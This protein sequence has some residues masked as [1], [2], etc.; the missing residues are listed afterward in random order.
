MT[1]SIA[2]IKMKCL[3]LVWGLPCWGTPERAMRLY[4]LQQLRH[5]VATNTIDPGLRELLQE[6]SNN[7][8]RTPRKSAQDQQPLARDTKERNAAVHN[9]HTVTTA[10]SGFGK[11]FSFPR[12]FHFTTKFATEQVKNFCAVNL[13][14]GMARFWCS[15]VRMAASTCC[16]IDGAQR[17]SSSSWK[18]LPIKQKAMILLTRRRLSTA[19]AFATVVQLST[20][21]R[22]QV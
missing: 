7:N 2:T 11:P 6:A 4:Q 20:L 17:I 21:Q 10:F 3:I 22:Y 1:N 8:A 16:Y 9:F 5:Q 12:E 19:A 15:S 18:M 13:V 14:K